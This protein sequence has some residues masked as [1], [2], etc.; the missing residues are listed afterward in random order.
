[1]MWARGEGNFRNKGRVRLRGCRVGRGVGA[2]LLQ[3]RA[4]RSTFMYSTVQIAV[5]IG[6]GGPTSCSRRTVAGIDIHAV[7]IVV[8]PVV[9]ILLIFRILFSLQSLQLLLLYP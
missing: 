2:I 9:S 1:M 3:A 8:I 5:P 7:L 6:C 4:G